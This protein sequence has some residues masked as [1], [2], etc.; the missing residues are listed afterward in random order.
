MSNTCLISFV[1]T[2]SYKHLH[3][4]TDTPETINKDLLAAI[5]KLGYKTAQYITTTPP[6]PHSESH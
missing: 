4:I 6:I 5:T 2:K 3:Q 1:S